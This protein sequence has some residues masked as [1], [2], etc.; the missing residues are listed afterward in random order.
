MS[1]VALTAVIQSRFFTRCPDLG[2]FV[3][4]NVFDEF[5]RRLMV[6]VGRSRLLSKGSFPVVCDF[7]RGN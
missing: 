7:V 4:D 3:G 1:I 2:G 5:A 6:V